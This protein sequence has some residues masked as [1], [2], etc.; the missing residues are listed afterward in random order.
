M[1]ESELGIII[2]NKRKLLQ[3]S[4]KDLSLKSGLSIKVIR[5]CENSSFS[6]R[7]DSLIKL[8]D[9]LHLDIKII[10]TK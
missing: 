1:K 9:A 5:H 3:M 6:I 2:K 4:Q 10:D 7:I 8:C